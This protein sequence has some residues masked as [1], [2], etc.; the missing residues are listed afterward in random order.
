MVGKEL[1]SRALVPSARV[2]ARRKEEFDRR[3]R[4]TLLALNKNVTCVGQCRR[5]TGRVAKKRA[6]EKMREGRG[7]AV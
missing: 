4:A 6:S 7:E 2:V 5:A 1:T 3:D